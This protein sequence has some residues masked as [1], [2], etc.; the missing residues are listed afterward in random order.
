M[1]T[2]S[3]AL[4]PQPCFCKSIKIEKD[5]SYMNHGTDPIQLVLHILTI[6]LSP[7]LLIGQVDLILFHN[8]KSLSELFVLI[9]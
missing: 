5:F 4:L 6:S 7:L 9:S 8:S 1:P 2:S 3:L